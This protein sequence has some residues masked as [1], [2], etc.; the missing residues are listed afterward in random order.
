MNARA[1]GAAAVPRALT[2]AQVRVHATHADV[3]FHESARIY[4]LPHTHADFV[5]MLARLH[6]AAAARVPV[7]VQFGGT[8]GEEIVQ[9]ARAP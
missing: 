1:S 2:V 7:D 8:A 5:A 4:R 6:D 9:V 3:M